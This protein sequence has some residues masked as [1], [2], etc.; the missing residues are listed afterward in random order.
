MPIMVLHVAATGGNEVAVRRE[1]NDPGD[2]PT[3]RL[4][5]V[6]G[7][8]P[9]LVRLLVVKPDLSIAEG[10]YPIPFVG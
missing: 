3:R 10:D 5:I 7:Q 6:A 1:S 4:G 2:A 8:G 9:L